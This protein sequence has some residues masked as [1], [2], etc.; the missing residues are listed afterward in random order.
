MRFDD[1]SVENQSPA[2]NKSAIT[3][4]RVSS[5]RRGEQNLAGSRRRRGYSHTGCGPGDVQRTWGCSAPSSARSAPAC[6]SNCARGDAIRS[7]TAWARTRSLIQFASRS[8]V[9]PTKDTA[10]V[11]DCARSA[12]RG[13]PAAGDWGCVAVRTIPTLNTRIPDCRTDLHAVWMTAASDSPVRVRVSAH[14]RGGTTPPAG[15][16]ATARMPLH[17]SV[18]VEEEEAG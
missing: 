2:L 16:R 14:T 6:C 5:R 7:H 15:G 9:C 1:G 11:K 4:N 3:T 10:A 13:G 12:H 18:R 17:G 8:L